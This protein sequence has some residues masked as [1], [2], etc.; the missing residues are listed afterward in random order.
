MNNISVLE[1]ILDNL[2]GSLR[3]VVLKLV[4]EDKQTETYAE[5]KRIL[6]QQIEHELDQLS[7]EINNRN[8]I[9][10]LSEKYRLLIPSL[11]QGMGVQKVEIRVQHI[12]E[13]LFDELE[14]DLIGFIAKSGLDNRLREIISEE[15]KRFFKEYEQLTGG[16][17]LLTRSEARQFVYQFIESFRHEQLVH[18][19]K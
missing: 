18:Y 16:E 4:E 11:L 12:G 2:S 19:L 14:G 5:A 10:R 6:T 13:T 8:V 1:N 3:S 7:D 15:R 9:Y 17:K